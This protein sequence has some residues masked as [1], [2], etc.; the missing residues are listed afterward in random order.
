MKK[1][2]EIDMDKV[3]EIYGY[4]EPKIKRE[5]ELMFPDL[6]I[7]HNIGNYYK[8]NCDIYILAEVNVNQVCLI[9]IMD[10][11]RWMNPVR[12]NN[13][14]IITNDDFNL[15]VGCSFGTFKHIPSINS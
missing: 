15:I 6:L 3:K 12:I 2:V 10:G 14:N 1:T 9:S 11:N 4:A 7:V 8:H 5:L 13:S